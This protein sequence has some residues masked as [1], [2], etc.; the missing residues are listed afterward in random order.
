MAKRRRYFGQGRNHRRLPE[1]N[2]L[3][4]P[5][6]DRAVLQHEPLPPLE[7]GGVYEEMGADFTYEELSSNMNARGRLTHYEEDALDKNDSYA[8][9]IGWIALVFSIMSLF[10]WSFWMGLASIALAY[11]SYRKGTTALAVISGILGLVAISL[12]VIVYLSAL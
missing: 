5:H 12:S 8:S 10:L 4:L 9:T 3:I 11:I 6:D 1:A 7:H 2:R